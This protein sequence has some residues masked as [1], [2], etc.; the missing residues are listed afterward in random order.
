MTPPKLACVACNRLVYWARLR[1]D[2]G[3]FSGFVK[4]DCEPK[5]GP[6]EG[7]VVLTL[8]PDN[9]L[10]ATKRRLEHGAHRNGYA[11]HERTCGK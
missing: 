2:D 3:A 9:T 5:T 1:A 10:V 6:L 8:S 11:L 4:V 7:D